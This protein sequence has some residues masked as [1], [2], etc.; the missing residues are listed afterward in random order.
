MTKTGRVAA[1]LFIVLGSLATGWLVE[2][3]AQPRHHHPPPTTSTTTT[4]TGPPPALAVHISGGDLVNSSGQQ[5]RLLGVDLTGTEN[6]CIE[7]GGFSWGDVNTPTE[8]ASTATAIASWHANAVRVPLN[9]D[10]WLGINGA[11]AAYSGANYRTAIGNLVT[12]LNG[13][14]LI[15]ILDLHWSAPGT[16]QADGQAPSPDEDHSP[17]FW[18]SVATTFK[19]DPAVIFDLFNEPFLGDQAS[20]VHTSADAWPCWLDGCTVT[21]DSTWASPVTYTSAGMQQ[22]VTAVRATGA[23]QPIDVAGIKWASDPCGLLAKYGST[24]ACPETA[25]MPTDPLHQLIVALHTYLGYTSCSTQSCWDQF[26]SGELN[27]VNTAGYP[28]V[29]EEFGE[30]DCSDTFMNW[31]MAWA[32]QHNQSYL[33]WAWANFYDEPTCTDGSNQNWSLLNT[34][35]GAPST[36]IPQGANFKNH[37]TTVN[38]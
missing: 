10:C 3:Q 8:D 7:N 16:H 12:A 11:L 14:G 15:A 22:L 1:V 37:L 21:A 34:W 9:E 26:W 19:S 29:T 33:A 27:G 5:I 13:Q 25:T 2:A 35:A 36:I 38:P 31:Y 32:D 6:A 4:T 28:M 17:A 24:A 20:G 30:A 23:T 18:T